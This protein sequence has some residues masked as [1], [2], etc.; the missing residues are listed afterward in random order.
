MWYRIGPNL[1]T[2]T[3]LKFVAES[4]TSAILVSCASS[5]VAGMVC[6]ESLIGD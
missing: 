6:L 4:A 2:E 5:V 3:I 1:I